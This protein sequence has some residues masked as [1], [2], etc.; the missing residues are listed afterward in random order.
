[1]LIKAFNNNKKILK[2]FKTL[3]FKTKH[4]EFKQKQQFVKLTVG[5]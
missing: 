1:M 3:A 5:I 4:K 2:L